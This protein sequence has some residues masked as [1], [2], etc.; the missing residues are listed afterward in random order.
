MIFREQV[1]A[2]KRSSRQVGLTT[3]S[4]VR[5][6]TKSAYKLAKA[7]I[8]ASNADSRLAPWKANKN[9]TNRTMGAFARTAWL[10]KLIAGLK[11]VETGWMVAEKV[12]TMSRCCSADGPRGTRQQNNTAMAIGCV[13]VIWIDGQ[14]CFAAQSVG[15]RHR[16]DSLTHP[17]SARNNLMTPIESNDEKNEARICVATPAR[18]GRGPAFA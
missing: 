5:R 15:S 2:A 4:R 8:G 13:T 7:F 11:K 12:S 3:S 1:N 6:R 9:K 17:Y 14:K 18:R 16:H 10:G